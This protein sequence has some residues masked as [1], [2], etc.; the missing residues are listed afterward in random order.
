MTGRTQPMSPVPVSGETQ[1]TV[2][3]RDRLHALAGAHHRNLLVVEAFFDVRVDAPGGQVVVRG[4][5]DER[6]AAARVVEHL[7]GDIAA[8]CAAPSEDDVAV[9]CRQVRDGGGAD[10]RLDNGVLR[11]GGKTFKGKTKAQAAYLRALA[12]GDT[13]LVFGVG[14]AGTGKTFLAVAHAAAQLANKTVDRLIIAR[15][16]VEAGEKLGYL[17]GDLNEKID[18]YMQPIWD[19]LYECMGKT[20]LEKRRESGAVEVAP[21]AYM[22]GRTLKNAFVIVDEAQNATVNQMHMVLTRLG[23]GSAMAVTGDPSQVDLG[24][25]QMSGLVHA[26]HILDGVEGVST[27]RFTGADVQRHPLVQRIVEAYAVDARA[28]GASARTS[29]PKGKAQ[30]GRDCAGLG[31]S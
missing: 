31:D 5:Q 9:V 15:P 21:L 19:A 28:G 6:A 2:T 8:G 17:P 23:E 3:D 4:A 12:A 13:P 29:S 26:L 1:I 7:L 22:R 16:A 30:P 24:P 20:V 27:V 11:V 25:S 14:P 10:F 18:P